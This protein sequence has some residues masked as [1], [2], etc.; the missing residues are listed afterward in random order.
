MSI[1]VV[2]HEPRLYIV[3]RNDKLL[4]SRSVTDYGDGKEEIEFSWV[5][6][7]QLHHNPARGTHRYIAR[8]G[9]T[10]AEEWARETLGVAVLAESM[11]ILAH[12]EKS[13]LRALAEGREVH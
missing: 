3:K 9:K 11:P 7:I 12:C 1:K 4:K 5:P 8:L 6:I 2:L 10:K 13:Y